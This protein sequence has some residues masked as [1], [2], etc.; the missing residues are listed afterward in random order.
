[1]FEHTVIG[2][3]SGL[4]NE[5]LLELAYSL[6]A[7]GG[8]LH[9]VSLVEVGRD[10]ENAR[11]RFVEEQLEQT[12]AQV[13][14]RGFDVRPHVGRA[15]GNAGH[16]LARYAE[17]FHADLLI[18]GLSKRTRVGK[19]L[20]GSDAQSALLSANCPVLSVHVSAE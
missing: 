1:M 14:E 16:S 2:L 6:T 12:A 11:L 15:S 10:E 13:R 9:L 17:E 18:L 3:K 5:P 7:P 8:Q 4:P 20:M 19:A